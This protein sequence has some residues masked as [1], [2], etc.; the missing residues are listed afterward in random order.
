MSKETKK[1]PF[2]DEIINAS[3]KVCPICCEELPIDEKEEECHCPYCN[4]VID[5]NSAV[6]PIC[7]ETIIPFESDMENIPKNRVNLTDGEENV[8]EQEVN[9]EP[10]SSTTETDPDKEVDIN[11]QSSL[12]SVLEENTNQA[13]STNNMG[14]NE[15]NRSEEHNF[16]ITALIILL[17]ISLIIIVMLMYNSLNKQ[18]EQTKITDNTSVVLPESIKEVSNEP[19]KAEDKKNSEKIKTKVIVKE[20]QVTP[21]ISPTDEI[22][23][24]KHSLHTKLDNLWSKHSWPINEDLAATVECRIARN[25]KVNGICKVIKS[26]GKYSYDSQ[27]ESCISTEIGLNPIPLPHSYDSDELIIRHTFK[28]KAPNIPSAPQDIFLNMGTG[29]LP[30]YSKETNN[31]NDIKESSDNLFN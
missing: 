10:L 1:C 21:K 27:A 25:G 23:D 30:N 3:E 29:T 9:V 13:F 5:K 14:Y 16:I 19:I 28:Y 20:V 12:N 26:S 4:E 6:C 7:Y 24:Y 15:Q 2:C 18:K 11:N 31:Q 22:N 17:I 8:Q